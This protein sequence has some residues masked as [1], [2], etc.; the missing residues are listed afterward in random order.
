LDEAASTLEKAVAICRETADP[1]YI[2]MYLT[3]L[4]NVR[5]KQGRR[6]GVEAMLAEAVALLSGGLDPASLADAQA[7]L[8]A[9]ATWRQTGED[10]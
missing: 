8:A 3:R 9:L 6:D 10:A 7:A 4:A 2:G 5:L 1:R